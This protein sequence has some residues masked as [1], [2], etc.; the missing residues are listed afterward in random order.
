M[1][2]VISTILKSKSRKENFI[3]RIFGIRNPGNFSQS[4]ISI[5]GAG[6]VA[7][8]LYRALK[9][10]GISASC[11]VVSE[12]NENL[13][14]NNLNVINIDEFINKCSDH[15][16]IM[17]ISSGEEVVK[18]NLIKKGFSK[19]QIV[20]LRYDLSISAAIADPTQ[21]LIQEL[22]KVGESNL[23]ILLEQDSEIIEKAYKILSDSY[24]KRLFISKLKALASYEN[25]NLL[26]DFLKSFSEPIHKYGEKPVGGFE[27]SESYFYF[28]NEFNYCFGRDQNLVDIGAYDGCSTFEFI[29]KC[30]SENI[31]YRVVAFEPDPNNYAA[32]LR[33]TNYDPNVQC[34]NKGVWSHKGR[35]KF[36]SSE[37]FTLKSSSEINKFG[38]INI[39]VDSLDSLFPGFPVT[40]IKADP[41][42][43]HVAIE[44]LKGCEK[45][46]RKYLPVLIFPAYHTFDAIYKM[47]TEINSLGLGYKIYLRHFSWSIQET[48]VIAI[49]LN[50]T[51][52][53]TQ[54]KYHKSTHRFCR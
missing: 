9:N 33:N 27:F 10:N 32:L 35:Q 19:K 49:P 20:L 5:F 50:Y 3:Q 40:I 8:E 17:G 51:L 23:R 21:N 13:T 7:N 12:L 6:I 24:S 4:K 45:T 39:E 52:G 30:T 2:S 48:D 15:L 16:L 34:I 44:V 36:K 42:R 18:N 38:N 37:R 28:N 26:R 31:K 54:D 22:R 41:P 14:K 1:A 53:P 43:L 47:P 46:I 25:V 29:K 11:F